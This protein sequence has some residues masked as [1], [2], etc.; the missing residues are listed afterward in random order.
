MLLEETVKKANVDA[1]EYARTIVYD[2]VAGKSASRPTD[3]HSDLF[4]NEH[5][6]DDEPTCFVTLQPLDVA[7]MIVSLLS[8]AA[9]IVWLFGWST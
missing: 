4:D 6:F 2:Y 9:A 7:M 1:V 8:Y 3:T 5:S